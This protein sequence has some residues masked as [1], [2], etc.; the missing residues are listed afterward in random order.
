MILCLLLVRYRRPFGGGVHAC[1]PVQSV[2]PA[3]A[4]V[5][6]LSAGEPQRLSALS[7]PDSATPRHR[8]SQDMRHGAACLL[9]A[10]PAR[11]PPTYLPV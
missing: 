5:Q 11:Y 6:G 8:H 9:P 4:R 2:H 3:G 10:L 7:R 1:V